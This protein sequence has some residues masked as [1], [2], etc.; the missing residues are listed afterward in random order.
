MLT[1]LQF[2]PGASTLSHSSSEEAL[3]SSTEQAHDVCGEVRS[4]S[5]KEMLPQVIEG[6]KRSS[7]LLPRW[8]FAFVTADLQR[9]TV[10]LTVLDQPAWIT[11]Y[12][13]V[14]R[15]LPPPSLDDDFLLS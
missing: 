12:R 3:S 14:L 13:L 5:H 8:A 9:G 10:R 1:V 6:A 11:I 15:K 2:L 4:F 7:A